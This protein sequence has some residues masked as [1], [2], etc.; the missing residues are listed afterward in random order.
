MHSILYTAADN[1]N[2][3]MKRMLYCIL[4]ISEQKNICLLV[5][6]NKNRIYFPNGHAHDDS[7]NLKIDRFNKLNIYV[8][9]S[10][11]LL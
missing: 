7:E 1:F 5:M 11:S 10:R 2:V 8:R 6:Y 3:P 4:E 9:G